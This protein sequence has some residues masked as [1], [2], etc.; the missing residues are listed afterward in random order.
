MRKIT[1]PE[2]RQRRKAGKETYQRLVDDGCSVVRFSDLDAAILGFGKQHGSDPCLIY[3]GKRIVEALMVENGM[4]YEDAV[5]WYGHNEECLYAGP[6]TPIVMDDF[7][8]EG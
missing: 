3:S 8:D 6:G 4:E 5:E 2:Y 1:T 7:T